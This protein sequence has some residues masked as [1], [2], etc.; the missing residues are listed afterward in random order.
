MKTELLHLIVDTLE[1]EIGTLL[2][3]HITYL[4]LKRTNASFIYNLKFRD[5][6]LLYTIIKNIRVLNII[7][8]FRIVS[9]EIYRSNVN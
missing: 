4:H 7:Y 3:F 8:F 2:N 1:L 9:I 6:S 5:L